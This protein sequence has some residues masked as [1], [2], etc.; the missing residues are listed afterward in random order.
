L[1]HRILYT[2]VWIALRRARLPEELVSMIT[3]I[4]EL[5]V[6]DLQRT[7]T[8]DRQIALKSDSDEYN[9]KI[10]FRTPPLTRKD[11][12]QLVALQLV[13]FACDQGSTMYGRESS[14]SWFELGVFPEDTPEDDMIDDAENEFMWRRSH[15]NRIAC[16]D[17]TFIQG[18]IAELVQNK[19]CSL[20]VGDCIVV[21]ARVKNPGWQNNATKGELRFWT[22]FEPVRKVVER[23]LAQ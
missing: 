13:T 8:C 9:S 6:P 4:A 2:Q 22:R 21:R 20:K 19:T 18:P 16:T 12:S 14:T 10:W 15:Y 5:H 17:P 11:L 23:R 1:A 7:L 3:R